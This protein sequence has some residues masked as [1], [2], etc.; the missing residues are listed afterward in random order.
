M[1]VWRDRARRVG[2]FSG[3]LALVWPLVGCQGDHARAIADHPAASATPI[4]A[5]VS[6]H[7]RVGG[8]EV[9]VTEVRAEASVDADAIRHQLDDADI[10]LSSCLEPDDS[11]GVIAMKVSMD[12]GGAVQE[13]VEQPMTT[14]GTDT[15]RGCVERLVEAMRFPA[16][17]GAA[18][19]EI[20]L[21]VRARRRGD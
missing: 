19:V 5:R 1:S 2:A 16:P 4:A 11:T 18:D 14:Y 20:T 9:H 21:E 15:S 7:G 17:H 12:A 8:M 3:A 10:A 13:V 6:D